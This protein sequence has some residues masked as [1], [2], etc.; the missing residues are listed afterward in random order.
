MNLI[1]TEEELFDYMWHELQFTWTALERS[2]TRLVHQEA[3]RAIVSRVLR[4]Y[5]MV[6]IDVVSSEIVIISPTPGD[7]FDPETME[8][9]D[10]KDM[11]AMSLHQPVLCTTDMG[12]KRVAME[13]LYSES[14]RKW[15]VHE[16]EATI[17][18]AK[19]TMQ[20]KLGI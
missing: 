1:L 3:L 11:L 16:H 8:V 17:L 12:L 7:L 15:T 13:R 14:E 18:K 19:V 6:R 4:L 9:S 2:K 20:G 10:S 5:R